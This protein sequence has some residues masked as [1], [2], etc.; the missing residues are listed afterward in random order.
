MEIDLDAAQDV[1]AP[2]RRRGRLAVLLIAAV[3][4]GALGGWTVGFRAGEKAAAGGAV[5]LTGVEV[6]PDGEQMRLRWLIVNFSHRD[7]R[8]A[9]VRVSGKDVPDATGAVPGRTVTEFSTTVGCESSD[10]PQL[11][12]G[13]VDGDGESQ[14]M[15]G[16]PDLGMWTALCSA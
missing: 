2:A 15:G 8:L 9:E 16:M 6:R 13:V 12:V 11:N 10:L 1:P 3:V 14:S 5:A 7:A 4:A